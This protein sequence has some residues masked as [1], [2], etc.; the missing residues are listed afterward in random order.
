MFLKVFFPK[1]ILTLLRSNSND[2]QSEITDEMETPWNNFSVCK[3][4]V[5]NSDTFHDPVTAGDKY[6]ME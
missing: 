2:C 6:L 3:H 1:I 5:A 4:T